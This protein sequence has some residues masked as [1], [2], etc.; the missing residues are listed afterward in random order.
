[1]PIIDPLLSQRETYLFQRSQLCH[2]RKTDGLNLNNVLEIKHKNDIK[3]TLIII[4]PALQK[5][6]TI[7]LAR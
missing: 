2:L 3:R 4:K 5:Y 7:F 1:M 6:D